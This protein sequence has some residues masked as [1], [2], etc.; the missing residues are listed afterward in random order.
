MLQFE[1]VHWNQ[2]LV[3]WGPTLLK[4]A[5]V[6]VIGGCAGAGDDDPVGVA[7]G[8]QHLEAVLH[9]VLLND[10]PATTRPRPGRSR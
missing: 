1:N 3:L 5:A 4:A 7:D 10:G 9:G 2:L 8:A 6:L